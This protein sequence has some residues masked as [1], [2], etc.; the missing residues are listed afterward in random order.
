MTTKSLLRRAIAVAGLALATGA[1]SIVVATP[2]Q[3]DTLEVQLSLSQ[4]T[5]YPGG[6]VTV[7]ET[8]TN[9]NDFTI[10]NPSARLFSAPGALGSYASLVSCTGAGTC[11][12]VSNASGPIGY[13]SVLPEALDGHVTTTVT[14]TL[15]I[16]AAAPDLQ[17]TLRGQLFGSNY[18]TGLVD[19]PTLTVDASADAVVSV[20]VTPTPGLLSGRFDFAVNVANGGPGVLRNAKIITTLPAGLSAK[21]SGSCLPN[22][23]K[24]VCTVDGVAKGQRATANFSVPFGLLTIGLPLQFTTTRTSSDSRDLN[25]ANDSVTTTCTVVTPLLVNCEQGQ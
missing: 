15:N 3:A 22:T 8:I 12:T 18:A 4:S 2:T 24:V 16:S 20:K 5:V 13:Q 6:T 1:T 17:E 9:V 11:S 10:L 19:G 23:G 14:F 25:P 21:G 7:T